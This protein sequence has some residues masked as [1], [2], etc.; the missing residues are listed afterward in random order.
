MKKFTLA[1][2]ALIT[3]V[4][5]NDVKSASDR[6][7][8]AF[9]T[10]I[11]TDFAASPVVKYNYVTEIYNSNTG[12]YE[13]TT[14]SAYAQNNGFSVLTLIYEFRYNLHEISDNFA[15]SLNATPALGVLALTSGEG[16]GTL[17]F[18]LMVGLEF[19]AG[20]TYNSSANA[21]GFFHA[22]I[23][24]NKMPLAGG[25]DVSMLT[26]SASYPTSW[27]N[28]VVATGIR[29]WNKNNKLREINLKYGFGNSGETPPV[30]YSASTYGSSGDAIYPAMTL[31]LSWLFWINY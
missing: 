14:V 24:F 1:L 17:N 31:R 23:E 25:P 6:I 22:G 27:V 15:I 29:Y 26:G 5:V 12:F 3:F 16:F 2:L 18:P 20:S 10:A 7:F 8:H 28:P 9:G 4:S 30:G 13:P 19:G 21:G 11:Y